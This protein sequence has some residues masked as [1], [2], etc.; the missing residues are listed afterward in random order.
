[1]KIALRSFA[2]T[3][4]LIT[5]LLVGGYALNVHNALSSVNVTNEYNA[6]VLT[7]TSTGTS[8]LIARAGSLGSVVI[9]APSGASSAIG[10]IVSFFDTSSTT[11]ATTTMTAFASIGSQNTSTP[12][13][14]YTFDA[15]ASSGILMWVNAAYNGNYTVTYR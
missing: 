5:L 9:T 4:A 6:R 13:G 7:T 10:P 11:R 15:T 2:A 8:T 1:M 14:T 12:A 3:V